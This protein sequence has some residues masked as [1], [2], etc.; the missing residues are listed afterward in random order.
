M[1][2]IKILLIDD[3]P[4]FCSLESLDDKDFEF[5]SK[6]FSKCI[7]DVKKHITPFNLGFPVFNNLEG[8]L[9]KY[10]SF[11]DHFELKWLHS[12]SSI[13]EYY[14]TINT[15]DNENLLNHK[16]IYIPDIVVFDYAMTG[17]ETKSNIKPKG[18]SVEFIEEHLD[19]LYNY[20]KKYRTKL[21]ENYSWDNS[22]NNEDRFG[23][24]SGGMIIERFRRNKPCF[25]VPSTYWTK[26]KL[27]KTEAGFFEWFIGDSFRNIFDEGQLRTKTGENKS[28]EVIIDSALKEFRNE[29]IESI[30]LQKI[31]LDFNNLIDL[32]STSNNEIENKNINYY[33]LYGNRELPLQGLFIDCNIEI[34]DNNDNKIISKFNLIE[35]TRR[36]VEIYKFISE[37][38]D[39]VTLNLSIS[40]IKNADASVKQLLNVFD[41]PIFT[42]RIMFSELHR[43]F[44]SEEKLDIEDKITYNELLKIFEIRDNRIV[45]IS[46]I[47]I[48][49]F[50]SKGK[51]KNIS[52]NKLIV[53]FAAI[54]LLKR[55]DTFM[56]NINKEDSSFRNR[57]N[58]PTESI[59]PP[60]INDLLLL[61]FPMWTEHIILFNE[62]GAIVK[63]VSDA[64][65]SQLTTLTKSKFKDLKSKDNTGIDLTGFLSKGEIYL[66][67]AYMK[68]LKFENSLKWLENENK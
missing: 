6:F 65:Q 15:L 8:K 9:T 60:D 34:D 20:R 43:K 48:G 68:S 53:S 23:L 39:I 41:Q 14:D 3:N 64:F 37:I 51:N 7:D 28:W 16:K 29:I 25:G 42:Q 47:T 33:S 59:I 67:K 11:L 45:N 57:Y 10:N 58:Q 12:T 21:I 46:Q 31:T 1:K 61:L 66:A 27:E 63:K 35:P 36:Q 13:K 18:Y 5:L 17:N 22:K 26:D 55:W 2:K 49:N 30:K 4:M 44:N 56:S 54:N 38:L 62:K 32:A 50:G 40:E 24:F 19:P 52:Y